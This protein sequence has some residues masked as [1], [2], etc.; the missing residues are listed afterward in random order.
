MMQHRLQL[1]TTLTTLEL[2]SNVIDYAGISEV[3]SALVDNTSL[4][5]LYVRYARKLTTF[6][7]AT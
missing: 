6:H 4:T 5:S 1:N 7:S 3:A 2:N